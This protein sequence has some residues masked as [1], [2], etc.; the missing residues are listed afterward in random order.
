MKSIDEIKAQEVCVA[1]LLDKKATNTQAK[2]LP[3]ENIIIDV[4]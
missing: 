3:S 1:I 4:C 2:I